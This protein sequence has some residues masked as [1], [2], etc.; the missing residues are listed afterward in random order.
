[1]QR[2]GSACGAARERDFQRSRSGQCHHRSVE[3]YVAGSALSGCDGG[4][5]RLFLDTVKQ[6]RVGSRCG[7]INLRSDVCTPGGTT[8]NLHVSVSVLQTR[9][10]KTKFPPS[11]AAHGRILGGAVT[12]MMHNGKADR[13]RTRSSKEAAATHGGAMAL[14][15]SQRNPIKL[16][17]S[18][19][20]WST[21]DV[22]GFSL[23]GIG[24]LP[25]HAKATLH[26]LVSHGRSPASVRG[27]SIDDVN[28]IHF[29]DMHTLFRRRTR[30]ASG[31]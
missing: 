29:S 17:T 15:L 4:L 2:V 5:R 8:A 26:A 24:G 23:G 10:S 6:V 31:R 28:A 27:F 13:E 25:Q 22:D 21:T 30:V 18:L 12:V 14:N 3:R 7:A 16:Q 1:M 11:T 20:R 9:P 19:R